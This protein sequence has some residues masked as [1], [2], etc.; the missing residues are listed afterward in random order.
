MKTG[1]L[2]AAHHHL[3]CGYK[4]DIFFKNCFFLQNKHQESTD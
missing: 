1:L 3:Y 4:S 2:A